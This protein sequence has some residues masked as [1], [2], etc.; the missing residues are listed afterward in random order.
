MNARKKNKGFTLPELIIFMVIFMIIAG[1]SFRLVYAV[2]Q[3]TKIVA[4]K[5]QI[6]QFAMALE[7]IKDDTGY[8]P[9]R[10]GAIFDE[11]P[12]AGMAKNWHGPYAKKMKDMVNDDTPLDPWGNPYFYEIPF[13]TLPPEVYLQTP[14]IGRTPGPPTRYNYTFT[15]PAGPATLIVTNYGISSGEIYLNGSLVVSSKEFKTHPR[16]QIITKNVTLIEGINNTAGSWLASSPNDYYT[17]AIGRGETNTTLPT[18]DY[19]I[20][21]SYGRDKTSG[22]SGFDKDIIFNSKMYPNFQ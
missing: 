21:G 17:V 13:T 1:I 2:N 7:N 15:A 10:L 20:L 11:N 16:P 3:K 4:A 22:G 6:S 9:V 19:F 18:S 5:T 14:D 8:Y 12:P